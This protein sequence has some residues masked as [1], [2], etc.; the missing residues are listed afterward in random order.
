M[1][2]TAVRLPRPLLAR[3][4]RLRQEEAHR[5]EFNISR[6]ALMIKL[7]EEALEYRLEPDRA[8]ARLQKRIAD[9][10][11]AELAES[12]KGEVTTRRA[13][14]LAELAR[15]TTRDA[16]NVVGTGET[17]VCE[18]GKARGEGAAENKKG[19]DRWKK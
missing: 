10:S 9:M 6:T 19:G 5:V 13:R 7:L 14:E 4:D 17:V 11:P 2:H 16:E 12:M 18:E 15:S 1:I 3:I 8:W